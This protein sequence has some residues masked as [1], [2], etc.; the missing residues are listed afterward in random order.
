[1]KKQIFATLALAATGCLGSDPNMNSQLFGDAAPMT[2]GTAG[3]TGTGGSGMV[4]G[5]IKG[6]G[7][8]LFDTGIEMFMFSPYNETPN[9]NA[10]GSTMKPTIA[11]DDAVGN[12]NPGALRITAP[13]SGSNQYVDVQKDFGSSN[14]QNLAGKTLYVRIRATEGTFMGGGV[15][16]YAITTNNFVFGGKFTNFVANSNWQEFNVNV[17]APTNGAG[18]SPS[19]GYDPTQVRLFGVQLNSGASGATSAPVT[20]HIDSFSVDPP[21]GGGGGAGGGAAGAGG[22]AGGSGGASGSGG[23]GGN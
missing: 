5:P 18:A 16:V 21:V 10:P 14:L 4:T 7:L 9:L 22:G 19:S 15:Q 23:A 1:M 12:P 17:S 13:Y 3:T 2:T 11:F 8:A 6:S 20:F